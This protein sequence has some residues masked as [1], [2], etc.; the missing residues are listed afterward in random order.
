LLPHHKQTQLL[1][2]LVWGLMK[3]NKVQSVSELL[4]DG[5]ELLCEGFVLRAIP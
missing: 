1:L 4:L 5:L 3:R 2:L